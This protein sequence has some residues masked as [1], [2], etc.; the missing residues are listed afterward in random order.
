MHRIINLLVTF[1]CVFIIVLP[2]AMIYSKGKHESFM[3]NAATAVGTVEAVVSGFILVDFNKSIINPCGDTEIYAFIT[4]PGGL[5]LQ[6]KPLF[7]PEAKA[8]AFQSEVGQQILFPILDVMPLITEA[9]E[10]KIEVF[11]KNT[12]GIGE[13]A[14]SLVPFTLELSDE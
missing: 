11:V 12:C 7:I 13:K 1:F 10:Y 2:S 5:P 6:L 9:G 3:D 8:T 14:I 4:T